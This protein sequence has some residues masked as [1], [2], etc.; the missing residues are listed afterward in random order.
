M[1][2]AAIGIFQ[3]QQCLNKL[4]SREVSRVKTRCPLMELLLHTPPARR[5][6][7]QRKGGAKEGGNGVFSINGSFFLPYPYIQANQTHRL[8]SSRS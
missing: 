5:R 6:G 7:L 3:S 1:N 8:E 2:E 4:L